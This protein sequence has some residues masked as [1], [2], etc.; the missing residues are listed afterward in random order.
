[1]QGKQIGNLIYV[2]GQ[3]ALDRE[4]N[5]VGEGDIKAQTR[6]ALENMKHGAGGRGA[7]FTT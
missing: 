3:V 7:G 5:V 2:A 4:G 6:Q 1:M